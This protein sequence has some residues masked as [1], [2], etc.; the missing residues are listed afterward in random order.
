MSDVNPAD[1]TS[2]AGRAIAEEFPNESTEFVSETDAA[3]KSDRE[4]LPANYR[5]RADAHYV[6]QLTSR[7][8]ERA[9]RALADTPR[10]PKKID[11][12]DPDPAATRFA[13]AATPPASAAPTSCSR[14]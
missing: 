1:V 7:R 5:M 12:L 9:E 8:A 11:T 14:R 3:R 4:G 13:I 6:D 2:A 10:A